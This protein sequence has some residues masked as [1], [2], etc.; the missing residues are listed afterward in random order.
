MVNPLSSYGNPVIAAVAIGLSCG[1]ACSP[2]V[3]LFLTTYTMGRFNSLQ[4]G[5]Q[6]FGYFWLGKTAVVSVLVFLSAL[7]GRTVFSQS[8]RIAS[9]DPRLIMDGCL[10]LTGSCLL[11]GMFWQ[12]R[13]AGCRSCGASSQCVV[14]PNEKTEKLPLVAMGAAYG[15]TP[16]SP[17]LLLL[18]MAAMLPPPQAILA[19]LVFTIA[20]SVSPLLILTV[21][22]GL[23]SQKM[24]REIPQLM[25]VFQINVFSLFIIVGCCSLLSHL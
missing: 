6:A 10:I 4:R 17:L 20:N 24:Q 12:R 23:I 21:L 18:I 25:R 8:R 9:I 2:L 13:K 11:A 3:N 14:L 15:L 1:T 19:G 5:L 7:F 22:A 16:C